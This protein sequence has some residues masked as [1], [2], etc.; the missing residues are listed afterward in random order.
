M[1]ISNIPITLM[2]N[3]THMEQFLAGKPPSD[4]AVLRE[5]YQSQLMKTAVVLRNPLGTRLLNLVRSLWLRG[6]SRW[7]RSSI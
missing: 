7:L 5:S 3:K 1:N 2:M 4:S 6:P